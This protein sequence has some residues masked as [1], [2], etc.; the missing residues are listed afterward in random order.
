[1]V[2]LSEKVLF[3]FEDLTR[4][5]G[6]EPVKEAG[7]TGIASVAIDETW[8]TMRLRPAKEVGGSKRRSSPAKSET[9]FNKDETHN[10][11]ALT[12]IMQ[13]LEQHTE[14]LSF[15]NSLAPF[16]KRSYTPVPSVRKPN[17]SE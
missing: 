5:E 2:Q 10:D 9:Q 4:D 13:E 6:W 8:S 17:R 3:V 15:F 11:T 14:C 7:Y 12:E 16:Y 1:M